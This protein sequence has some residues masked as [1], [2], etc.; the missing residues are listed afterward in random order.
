M[1][2]KQQGTILIRDAQGEDFDFVYQAINELEE[3]VFAYDIQRQIFLEHLASSRT[4]Y[5]IAE[6]DG[7]PVGFVSCHVQHLL[8]HGGLIG[9]IQEMYVIAECRS[10]NV[11]SKLLNE[12]IYLAQNNGV[13]QIEVTSNIKRELAHSFYVRNGFNHTHKKFTFKLIN[14]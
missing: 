10:K 14:Y 13:V 9:E 12:V 6:Y 2:N 3:T 5:L 7:K 1:S 4:I 8:H 11:G